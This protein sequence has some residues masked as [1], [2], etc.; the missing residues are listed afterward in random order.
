[1]QRQRY[2]AAGTEQGGSAATNTRDEEPNMEG[3]EDMQL[4]AG[5]TCGDCAHVERCLALGFT[6][7]RTRTVC[8]F[9]PSRFRASRDSG[10][11]TSTDTASP[12]R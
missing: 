2:A 4:P 11:G 3:A 8:D 6:P 9:S 10:T 1:M 12:A 7:S 5:A